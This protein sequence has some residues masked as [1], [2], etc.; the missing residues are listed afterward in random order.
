VNRLLQLAA[1][2]YDATTNNVPVMINNNY[3]SVFRPLFSRDAGGMGTNL[4]ISGYTNVFS[5]DLNDSNDHQADPPID[6]LALA[7]TNTSVV[8]SNWAVNV[9]GVPWIIGA[10]KGF[11]NFN[12]FTFENVVGIS[13]RLQVTRQS[14]NGNQPDYPH[15]RTNQMYTM[16][17]SNYLGME[18]WNSYAAN[19]N[20]KVQ[21]AVRY[22]LSTW[23]TNDMG[24]STNNDFISHRNVNLAGTPWVWS[25]YGASI[26]TPEANSFVIPLLTNA[27]MLPESVYRFTPVPHFEPIGSNDISHVNYESNLPAAVGSPFPFPHFGMVSTNRLQAF[28][29]DFADGA[30]RVI[31]YVHFEQISR[32]DLN[33][34]LLTDDNQGVW[35][36]IT[37][38]AQNLPQSVL[39]QLNISR[40]IAALSVEQD[41]QWRLDPQAQQ[42]FARS[43]STEDEQVF[44]DAFFKPFNRSQNQNGVR[45]TNTLL[46]AQVPYSPTRYVVECTFMQANDPLVHYLASDLHQYSTNKTIRFPSTA[47]SYLTNLNGLFLKGL[48]FRELNRQYQPWGGYPNVGLGDD[49]NALALT[50]NN[51]FIKD[52]LVR[53]SDDWDFPTN[54]L[55][56]IGWL[57]RVHRGTPWQTVYLK[58]SDV[59]RQIQLL[60]STTNHVGTNIWKNWTGN[61][62]TFD[63]V[64]AAPAEDRLLFDLFTTAFN[65]NATRGTLSVNVGAPNGPSLAAWSA[66]FGGLVVP[67]NLVGAYTV[68]Q[69]AGTYDATLPLAQQPFLVQLVHGINQTRANT[70]LFPEQMFARAGDVLAATSLTESSP[71]LAG[72]NPN[73]GINDQLYEWLPQQTMGLLRGASAPRYVI[74]SYGQTL[75][76]APGGVYPVG[77]AYFG[78]VTN[79]QVVSETASRA[80]VRFDCLRTNVVTYTNEVV[81]II[82][83]WTWFS[84]PAVTNN[85]VV[86][87]Q[88]NL[89]P[90]D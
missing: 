61:G 5:V 6:A 25:G 27:I 18:F 20:G 36:A 26:K 86:I 30:Y 37:N 13:R 59:L 88:F 54:K 68:V 71:F 73:T 81:G 46:S 89:L 10:K 49:L 14:L 57:G 32:R 67:T 53:T 23:L 11:P 21:I 40:A 9:Y 38:N 65:D 41:G 76:P 19:Y 29:L 16:S 83:N 66:V 70:N 72:L 28:V 80:V 90:P 82:T 85:N 17:I 64:N 33:A 78:M 77:G 48:D 75:K 15:F 55:P 34:D 58:A 87:E 2:L 45:A 84:R 39:N 50:T 4:F 44:F 7:T 42:Q 43:G 63:A 79:Y 60:G 24:Y 8:V 31:D 22:N 12:K 52:P 51:L 62:S 1:N 47:P 69:P 74:Y 35:T 56:T 3:P